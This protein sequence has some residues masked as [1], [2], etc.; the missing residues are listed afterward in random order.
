MEDPGLLT[1]LFVATRQTEGLL[2]LFPREQVLVLRAEALRDDRA[3]TLAAVRG[4]LGLPPAK[5]PAARAAHVG[6]EM[7]YGSEFTAQDAIFLR[8]LYAR[9][10]A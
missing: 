6:R 2:G 1:P 4:F 9:D 7:D 5:P 10:Q 3:A 8:N